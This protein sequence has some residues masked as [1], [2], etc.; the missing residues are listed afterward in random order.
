MS[1]I[2]CSKYFSDREFICFF[3]VFLLLCKNIE[4]RE[5]KEEEEG[6]EKPP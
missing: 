6:G 5:K 4:G 3:V 1:L 2:Y